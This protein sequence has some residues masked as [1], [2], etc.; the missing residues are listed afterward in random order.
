MIDDKFISSI[1]SMDKNSHTYIYMKRA[2]KNCFLSPQYE[3]LTY[4]YFTRYGLPC[5]G[6]G[7]E[8]RKLA[9]YMVFNEVGILNGGVYLPVAIRICGANKKNQDRDFDMVM[10]MNID[11]LLVYVKK[12]TSLCRSKNITININEALHD[13]LCWDNQDE[14]GNWIKKKWAKQ[15]Y[16]EKEL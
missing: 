8:A 7:F 4:R 1:G 5:S 6:I 12:I 13:M 11:R 9:A 10:K 14:K 3:A 2:F 15:Y 16:D